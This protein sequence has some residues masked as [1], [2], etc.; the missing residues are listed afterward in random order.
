[1][2]S[3]HPDAEYRRHLDEGRFMLQRSRSSGRF[4]FPPRVAEPRTG[5]T[6]LEWVD[7]SGD[8]TVHATTVVHCKPPAPHYNVALIDLAEGARIMSR[9]VG[10]PPDEVAIGMPVRARVVVEDA[11]PLVV[12]EPRPAR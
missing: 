9:V 1:M 11:A 10:V 5:A 8:G 2:T 4:V 12:F 3:V 7:L 6:D